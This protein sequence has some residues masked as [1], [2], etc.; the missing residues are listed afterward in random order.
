MRKSA[1]LFSFG[2][3]FLSSVILPPMSW[4][5]SPMTWEEAS[6]LSRWVVPFQTRGFVGVQGSER[7]RS[8]TV[9]P[10]NQFLCILKEHAKQ[11]FGLR[12]PSLTLSQKKRMVRLLVRTRDGLIRKDAVDL[13]LIQRFES[14]VVTPSVDVAALGRI[15]G[16]I[17]KVEGEEGRLFLSSLKALQEILSPAQQKTLAE[18]YGVGIPAM[19]VDLSSAVFFAD[20]I[21]SIRWNFLSKLEGLSD[22]PTRNRYLAIYQK[23]RELVTRLGTSMTL[24]NRHEEDLLESPVVDFVALSAQYEKA[25]PDEGAFWG[26]L[27]KAIGRLNPPAVHP[28]KD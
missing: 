14:R 22:G 18:R 23:E 7:E 5:D 27:V 15:N 10:G 4:A 25:G 24:D 28:R 26:E 17:G 21:L 1:V 16:E 12:S 9:T 8:M 11:Y 6:S 19:R 3:L 2:L 13:A 20:R